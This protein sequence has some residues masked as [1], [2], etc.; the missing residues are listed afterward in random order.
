MIPVRLRLHNFLCYRDPVVLDFTGFRFACLSGDNGAGKSALLDAI[1]WA[2]WGRARARSADELIHLNENEMSVEFEFR[3]GPNQYRVIR[4]RSRTARSGASVLDLQL[5]TPDGY[6]SIAGNSVRET[7]EQ[8]RKLLRLDYE[9]FINSAFILQNRADEFTRKTPAERKEILAEILGLSVYEE[10]AKLARE[11]AR[12]S[13]ERVKLLDAQA[14]ELEAEVAR[15]P[16][17]RQNLEEVEAELKAVQAQLEEL[18]GVLAEVHRLELRGGE[19]SACR[20][21]FEQWVN[22]LNREWERLSQLI[23]QRKLDRERLLGLLG[24]AE[25]IEANFGRWQE[26]QQEKARLDGLLRDLAQLQDRLR[27]LDVRLRGELQQVER[28]RSGRAERLNGL[29]E[30]AAQAGELEERV[31]R[32]QA[33]REALEAEFGVKSAQKRQLIEGAQQALNELKAAQGTVS[34][35]LEDLRRRFEVLKLG[36]ERCPVCGSPLSP[37]DRRRLERQ[38]V[39]EGREL[40]RQ[41]QAAQEEAREREAELQ[42][43]RQELELLER[44]RQRHLER[45]NLE[46]GQAEANLRRSRQAAA[47]IPTLE[48]EVERLG[49]LAAAIERVL[50]FDGPEVDAETKTAGQ[51]LRQRPEIY[52]TAAE[53]VKLK[54]R[55]NTLGY[56]GRRHQEVAQKLEELREFPVLKD[57]LDQ[58]RAEL[59]R[60]EAELAELERQLK[61]NE[62]RLAEQAERL[63]ELERQRAALAQQ[64]PRVPEFCPRLPALSAPNGLEETLRRIKREVDNCLEQKSARRRELDTRRGSLRQL[65]EDCQRKAA[66]LER[67]RSQRQQAAEEQGLYE[68]LGRAFG[69]KGVPAMVI[70]AAIP[71]IEDEANRLITSMTDQR[72]HI[73]FETQ[74][75]SQSGD[76]IETLDIKICDELG[77]RNYELYSGGE[78]FRINL[79]I[80]IALSR[81]LARRAGAQLNMLVIDEGFGSQDVA[82]RERLV[83]TIAGVAHEFEKLLV[84]THLPDLKDRFPVRVEVTRGERGSRVTVV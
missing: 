38:Y 35:Q 13:A 77:T 81:L 6:R 80:R 57:R 8:I 75:A 12:Q 39:E 21:D 50:G 59:P 63:A 82:A 58:A 18:E 45:V 70:E 30:Q 22:H 19:L 73:I 68:E 52:K 41:L 67:V 14:Q 16:V 10:L 56:D 17:Y 83:E 20:R 9:T 62:A 34:R 7:E 49:E 72:M 44:E 48:T 69:K 74:R 76:T 42:R 64:V 71:E 54:L 79:A 28:E 33:D 31:R 25:G 27:V 51:L 55:L 29:R 15:A 24:R 40:K 84:I 2:L 37:E 32:L 78:A 65:L 3:L 53:F 5:L 11:R 36:T 43:L 23:G 61:E 47:E 26:L 60:V 46:L 1:T 66:E 4:R